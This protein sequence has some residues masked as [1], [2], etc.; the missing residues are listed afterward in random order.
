[1][2]KNMDDLFG[3]LFGKAP[4][5]APK[6]NEYRSTK[7]QAQSAGQ[8]LRQIDDAENQL[9]AQLRAQLE[10]LKQMTSEMTLQSIEDEVKRDF[11]V[12]T[13]AGGA[14]P[15][16]R[17]GIE[18]FDAVLPALAQKVIGQDE[19]LHKLVIAFKRPYVAGFPADG[20]KNAIFIH[21]GPASGK[22]TAVFAMAQVLR[23]KNVL[24]SGKVHT[25]DLSHYST[26]EEER[27]FLQDL[28]MA[29]SGEGEIVVFDNF[30][31][32]HPSFLTQLADLVIHG[33]LRLSTRYVLQ[34]GR[35]IDAGNALTSEMIGVINAGGKYL[36]FISE[37]PTEKLAASFGAAF[38]NALGD[39]CRTGEFSGES[40]D[41]IAR[42]KLDSLK[43]T[44]R[45]R[46]QLDIACQDSLFTLA[47]G[48][49]SAD[50]GV[51]G[52]ADYCDL[53]FKALAQYR[54]ENEIKDT[55]VT[56]S[57]TEGKLAAAIDGEEV[58]LIALL[59]G[60]YTGELEAIKTEMGKVVGLAEIKSYILSLADHYEV[61]K[62]RREEGLKAAPVSMHMIF[63]G[64][65]G[66]GK[67]TIARLVSKY[68]KVIG[69]LSG[70]QLIEV[71]RAD[72]VG[73]YVG[74]T[75]PLTTKVI[76]SAIGGVL[77]IDEAYSLYRGEQDS[78]GLEAIDTLVKG[79]EDNRDNLLVVLAGYSKEMAEFMTANSG[80]RSRF[81][82]VIEFPDYSGE[83]LREI[84]NL[85]AQDKGYI[86]EEDAQPALLDYFNV[87]QA[88]DSRESGNGRLARNI[89]EK[90]IL[91]QSKRV[92]VKRDKLNILRSEDFDLF[93]S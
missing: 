48:K 5:P 58:D 8:V 44:A 46:M 1:M 53:I 16:A 2:S 42:Q 47:A 28:Y 49:Y 30:E 84:A 86:I 77:F 79:I 24:P 3:D 78:F 81:P 80:L 70:G 91:E 7:P 59:P 25:M 36:V 83:E 15:Q 18:G 33:K 85:Q 9:S 57:A 29:L 4:K 87:I 73:K 32:C 72:L 14:V 82:N 90:A 11:G 12:T 52:I 34:K 31:A 68:L 20:V 65:P 39:I 67:T 45:E 13:A 35:L 88:M 93:E 41:K 10:E 62:L 76:K 55:A 38:V 50:R 17:A 64:N 37:K 63:T 43:Q 40:L 26:Q 56:L 54:L 74:H 51:A 92:V 22:H 71:T 19:L 60:S 23:E 27:L 66:T 61:Q 75:A 21:G 6:Q 69:V 89:V